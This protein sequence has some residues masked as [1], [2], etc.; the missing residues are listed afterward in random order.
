MVKEKLLDQVR[1]VIRVKHF[2]II[3][4]KHLSG[5]VAEYLYCHQGTRSQRIKLPDIVSSAEVDGEKRIAIKSSSK[6]IIL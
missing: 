5:L 6:R 4:V 1:Y 2:S 3:F